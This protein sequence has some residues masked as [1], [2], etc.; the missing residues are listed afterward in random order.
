MRPKYDLTANQVYTSLATAQIQR[1][2]S[3]PILAFVDHETV[4][5]TD[6]DGCPTP[7]PL[8]SWAPDWH[9]PC[10]I[11]PLPR[12]Y[13]NA[14]PQETDCRISIL[15]D[16]HVLAIRGRIVDTISA[17]SNMLTQHDIPISTQEAGP[18]KK[19]NPFFLDRLW[20]LCANSPPNIQRMPPREALDGISLA[21][22]GGYH[23]AK[24]VDGVAALDQHRADFAAYVCEYERIRD[25]LKDG[26]R[27]C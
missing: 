9:A 21:L 23:D 16:E 8:P 14:K 2:R 20:D 19:Q 12:S 4:V 1:T 11:V 25:N 10:L 27:H 22:A 17:T 3:L 13:K 18:Q 5:T 26:D 15:Q 7:P 6:G 24:P